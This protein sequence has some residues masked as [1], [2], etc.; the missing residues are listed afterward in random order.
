M[1]T[2]LGEKCCSSKA[3]VLSI[4]SR[5]EFK[6][7]LLSQM[8]YRHSRISSPLR[9]EGREGGRGGGRACVPC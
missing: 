2:L 5:F 1:R 8:E 3:I 9:E 6:N 7:E 4:G